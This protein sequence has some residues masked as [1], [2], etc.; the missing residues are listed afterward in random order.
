MTKIN[1]IENKKKSD[2][3]NIL[4][5]TALLFLI[6][7]V[8]GWLLFFKSIPGITYPYLIVCLFSAVLCTAMWYS[9]YYIRKLFLFLIALVLVLSGISVYLME[10]R[11]LAQYMQ[12][13][14][15][16]L[17]KTNPEAMSVTETAFLFATAVSVIWFLLEIV[18]QSHVVLYLLTTGLLLFG[19]LLGMRFGVGAV[20]LSV[21]FQIIFWALHFSKRGRGSRALRGKSIWVT[22]IILAV[23]FQV[24]SPLAFLYS[25][26]LSGLAF[27]AEG[28]VYRTVNRL[29]GRESK[30][31]DGGRIRGGN[32][33]RTGTGHLELIV[34]GQPKEHLYLRGFAGGEYIGGDWTEADDE[35]VFAAMAERLNWQEWGSWIS[36]MYYSM[37]YV[38]NRN[39]T[40]RGG[41]NVYDIIIR[42]MNGDYRN[43]YEPY[44]SRRDRWW[45]SSEEAITSSIFMEA[46]ASS[47]HEEGYAYQY[48]EQPDMAVDWENVPEDFAMQMDWYKALRDAYMEEI[49][50][51]Y[52]KVPT[53]LLPRLTNL[54]KENP[55]NGSDE[56]SAFILYTLH[57]NAS[58]T[59]TPGWPPLNEDIA[60]YFLFESGCGYCEHFALT[61]T[62]MY[63]MYGIPARY[64]NGYLVS[65][66][67][68]ELQEDG[69]YRAVVTDE[70]AHAWTEIF[71]PDYGWSPIE[72][73]PAE[74]GS[75]VA[76]Y[77]GFGGPEL[78]RLLSERN[79]N[80]EIPS[81]PQSD[82]SSG[83]DK[84]TVQDLTFTPKIALKKYERL[85]W[86]LGTVLLYSLFM[87]P[88]FLDYRRLRRLKKM[89]TMNCR[90]VFS[91]FMKMLHFAGYLTKYDGS[92][93]EFASAFASGIP[94]ISLEEIE[95]LQ[96]IVCEAAY[97]PDSPTME[98]EIYVRNIYFRTGE[99]V[100]ERLKW[101]RKLVFR[102]WK[103]F[104]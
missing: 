75:T 13:R 60:E 76:E 88:L 64:A 71:L 85:L 82:I 81:L 12:I 42:H 20:V 6:T 21:F 103:T 98:Q 4:S 50:T 10:E 51:V 96:M 44:Y 17:E 95:R 67:A 92:E 90:M 26:E 59:L 100:Y 54:V 65:P 14:D 48:F 83:T 23:S 91:K 37:Y 8:Y 7:G 84:G 61:A 104:G 86:I 97:G 58:Y 33:Y 80:M 41:Q 66:A 101:N 38:M 3:Q 34:S 53:E 1:I 63:R 70:D 35:E 9:Y 52:T 87:I 49:R 36:I 11:L 56:I 18:L 47:I 77:P 94:V 28:Y 2:K 45:N 29:S 19:P 5:H 15:C 79:W 74:D 89:E 78:N 69:T 68:F 57:S 102:Y 30:P 32:N 46:I 43:S 40:E 73:T 31:I 55:M 22:A 25:R 39:M 99:F 27:E 62:L 16:I 93:K 24:V 72:V